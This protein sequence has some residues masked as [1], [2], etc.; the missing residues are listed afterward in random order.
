M[1]VIIEYNGKTYESVEIAGMTAKEMHD[2][3][4]DFMESCT[5]FRMELKDG[6][7]LAVGKE[8]MQ[9]AVFIFK[10]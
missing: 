2:K 10:D 6:S 3:I 7:Y 5:K 4:S 1:K 8:V 9:S